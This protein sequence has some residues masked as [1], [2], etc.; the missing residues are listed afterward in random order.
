MYLIYV[1]VPED[2]IESVKEAL[3]NA[4][5]GRIGNYD[6]CSWQAEG[7]GQFRPLEGSDPFSGETGKVSRDR[8]YRLELTARDEVVKDVLSALKKSHPYE[9]PAYGAVRIQSLEDFKTE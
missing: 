4:G 6:R 2:H 5:G 1:Y 3:F 7:E 9:E 8:E